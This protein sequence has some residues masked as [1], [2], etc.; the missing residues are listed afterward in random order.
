MADK[1]KIGILTSGG[2]APGMN[3]CVRAVVRTAIQNGFEAYAI[4]EGYYGIFHNLLKKLNREDV[5]DII[6]KGG[7]KIGTA[8]F[9]E[10]KNEEVQKQ[11]AEILKKLNFK[12]VVC[13]GGDGTYAGAMALTK[14]GVNCIGLPGTIDNDISSS[15][16]TIGFDTALNTIVECID[17][18]KDTSSSHNRCAIVEVMGRY[19]PDLATF[20]GLA[21]GAEL[22]ITS[23]NP[24]SE[25]EILEHM[26]KEHDLG[27]RSAL[28]VVAEHT[29]DVN[30]LAKKVEAYSGYE[31]RA[32][33][34]GHLQRGG[35]PTAMDR[36]L[37]SRLGYEAVMLLKENKGGISLGLVENKITA[38]PILNS[39]DKNSKN[40]NKKIEISTELLKITEAIK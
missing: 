39:L 10:L 11:A 17:K 24:M 37:A 29:V 28:I 5:S 33:I 35:S 21:T 8:R 16:Y 14:F 6:G 40:H 25:E 34:L 3:A 31:T 20:A 32:T 12:G 36:V 2:D 18:I 4:E 22:V 26:K 15:D 13:I 7:T 23:L 27:K 30:D 1:M 38:S 19:C 9:P